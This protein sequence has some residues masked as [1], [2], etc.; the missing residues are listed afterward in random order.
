[1]VPQLFVTA[2]RALVSDGVPPEW[3]GIERLSEK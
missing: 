3:D 2:C 1:V